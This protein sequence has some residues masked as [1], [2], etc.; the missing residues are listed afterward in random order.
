MKRKTLEFTVLVLGLIIISVALFLMFFVDRTYNSLFITNIVFAVGFLI[1]IIYTIMN[2]NSL[3]R[4]IKG[5]NAHVATLK[6]NI[7][8][9]NK[10]LED[11]QKRIDELVTENESL[12]SKTEEL[13]R[14]AEE[15]RAELKRL[16][17]ELEQKRSSQQNS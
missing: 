10:Q 6:S 9:K 1:Y 5:L 3:N 4:E 12:L 13:S 17:R 11:R 7:A 8:E 14:S 16:G 2:T 15:A